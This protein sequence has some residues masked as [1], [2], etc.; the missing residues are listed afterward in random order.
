MKKV[1]SVFLPI[2][3]LTGV[4]RDRVVLVYTFMKGMY[5]NVGAILRQNMM[6]FLN[7]LSWGFCYGGLITRFLR[8]RE[9]KEEELEMT[10]SRHPKLTCKLVDVTHTKELYTLH[11]PILSAPNKKVHDDKIIE[12]IFGMAEF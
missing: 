4:A 11:M 3:H 5:V 10:V 7:N 1:C 9:I 6:K 8:S 12:H 2:K